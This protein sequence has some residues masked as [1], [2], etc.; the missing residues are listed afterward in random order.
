M[1]F[2]S[3]A[4]VTL[5]NSAQFGISGRCYVS[6]RF[7]NLVRFLSLCWITGGLTNPSSTEGLQPR[8]TMFKWFI[9]FLFIYLFIYLIIDF[10]VTW[11]RIGLFICTAGIKVVLQS[12]H[13]L[14]DCNQQ[15][16][17]WSD[18]F[19]FSLFIYLYIYLIIDF[20]VTWLGI[21]LFICSV[22][23]K[24]VLQSPHILK[25][26][27]QQ[28]QFWSDLFSFS[29]FIYLFIYLSIYLLIR[30]FSYLI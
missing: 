11:F 12:P 18:L 27:K 1:G 9:F 5:A 26:C 29:F 19:S 28:I 3:V 21:A 23:L 2:L 8:N 10:L 24:V 7:Q 6:V 25:D 20:L 15:I 22:G 30:F 4:Y 17:C 14:K 16:Q 13:L